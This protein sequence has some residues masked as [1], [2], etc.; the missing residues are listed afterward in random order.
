M[1]IKRLTSEL[2][3]ESF[4]ETLSTLSPVNLTVTKAKKLFA[5]IN[6]DIFVAIEKGIIGC[7]TV[8]VEQKLIHKGGRVAHIEDVA[9]HPNY[10][11]KGV[12]Y[13]LVEKIIEEASKIE[14]YK[15]IL[16]CLPKVRGFYEKLG[17]KETT[18]GMR[19]DLRS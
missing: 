6:S 4:I 8:F 15:I 9:V 16:D 14:C 5:N 18:I 3:D 13:A 10:Q 2:I 19:R 17:F 1:K 12:G 11:G 7:A